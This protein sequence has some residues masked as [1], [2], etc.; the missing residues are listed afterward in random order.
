MAMDA[1]LRA[2][3][4]ADAVDSRAVGARVLH[5]IAAKSAH[6]PRVFRW[7]LATAAVLALG[8]TGY[9][10][11]L[12]AKANGTFVAAAKDHHTEVIDKSPRKWR[13]DLVAVDQLAVREGVSSAM[14]QA[15][16]PPGYHFEQARLCRLDGTVYLH[17]V[18]SDAAGKRDFSVFLDG[19]DR[20]HDE[21][22]YAAS[23]GAE[24]VA[25]FEDGHVKAV[26]V[27]DQSGDSAL[28]FAQYAVSVIRQGV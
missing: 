8:V 17:L 15:I 13:S 21:K 2:A 20:S 5:S 1:R 16:A 11:L 19:K 4:L 12:T 7:A 6:R 18:Y 23:I 27:T 25:G 14:I 10:S 3:V 24:H 9:R 22:I 26:I 28:R